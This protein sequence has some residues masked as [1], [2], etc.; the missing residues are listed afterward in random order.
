MM[1]EYQTDSIYLTLEAKNERAVH[2]YTQFGFA[3]TGEMDGNEAIYMY[4]KQ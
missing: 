4:K 3:A 2:L 1:R